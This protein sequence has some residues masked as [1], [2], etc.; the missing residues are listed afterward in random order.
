MKSTGITAIDEEIQYRLE[1][2]DTANFRSKVTWFDPDDN[3]YVLNDVADGIT[4]SKETE[5]PQYANY[6]RKPSASS[7]SFTVINTNGDY[8]TESDDAKSTILQ[9]DRKVAI[10]FG[11]LLD[12]V[13]NSTNYDIGLNNI[14]AKFFY[15]KYNV[16][17]YVEL[18]ATNASAITDE[19]YQDVFDVYYDSINYGDG[20]YTPSGY[21]VY[22]FD[23]IDK[24]Y[25]CFE[26]ISV[27][28]NSTKGKI[29]YRLVNDLNY[30]DEILDDGKEST[31]W[32]YGTDTINGTQTIDIDM[33]GYRYIQVGI[34]L[35]S[36]TWGDGVQISLVRLTYQS[37]VQWFKDNTFLLDDPEFIEPADPEIPYVNCTGRDAWKRAI[38][39]EINLPDLSAG[40]T[41]DELIKTICDT[42]NI[43][44][45]LTSIADLSAFGDRVL[46]DGL[47]EMTRIDE[48]FEYLMQIV[49]SAYQ[50]WIDLD[51]YLNVGEKPDDYL[52]DF[53][54][55]YVNYVSASKKFNRS[56][57][58]KRI[59]FLTDT[60]SIDVEEVL[61]S[62]TYTTAGTKV[63]D[64][65]VAGESQS[66]T[67]VVTVNSGSCTV[68]LSG[69]DLA[70]QTA[71]FVITGTTFNVTIDIY[72]YLY[73][74]SVPDF[75]GEAANL[76]NLA[77]N[78]GNSVVVVN[79]L[80]ISNTEAT[81]MADDYMSA[82][83]DPAYSISLKYCFL[84]PLL[85]I[86]D[87]IMMWSR[88]F[89]DENLY[90]ITGVTNVYNIS[91]AY[92]EFILS[93]TGRKLS[94]EGT[95]VYDRNG[96]NIGADD[97]QYDAG[98]LYDMDLTRG[99][100]DI[101]IYDTMIKFY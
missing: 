13:G 92:T 20:T 51:G 87:Q 27:T 47:G 37:Y 95:F 63:V 43:E 49:G 83:G 64:W 18:D 80:I 94:Q 1:V 76:T 54:F 52:V 56:K 78:N 45:T 70:S 41:I 77:A 81:R 74:S 29:Y 90:I 11:I 12:A 10:Y 2:G 21:A 88:R 72:G 100:I 42:A 101:N 97:I 31:S 69:I 17:G 66:I 26:S 93:D 5:S 25:E 6:D 40:V 15:T 46:A 73:A 89:Y 79:P 61:K 75:Y 84:M 60:Q 39:T 30:V 98:F 82:Y 7:C 62:E 58:L 35:Y 9:K 22:T 86:N 8:S 55:N 19:N 91:S 3:E 59:T 36:D 53:V 44:Y 99:G 57:F 23:R 85:E 4:T 33:C 68:T 14:D 67:P 24:I 65:S 50:M 32:T 71:T 34:I 48:I 38:E 16:G 28:C 96:Y